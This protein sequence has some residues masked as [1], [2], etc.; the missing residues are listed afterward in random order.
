MKIILCFIYEGF[1]DFEITLTCSFL[2]ETE[3]YEIIYIAYNKTPVISGG[4]I[5][6]IPDKY[7]SEVSQTKDIEGIIIPGG[8]KRVLKPELRELISQL[9]QEKKLIAAICAGP[10]FLAKIGILKGITFTTSRKPSHYI[11]NNEID[12]FPRETY[13][14]TRVVQDGN[15]ITAKGFAFTDFALQIWDWFNLFDYNSEK[16]EYKQLYTP[17]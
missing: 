7:V 13:V 16:E 3:G 11:D 14:D 10:E 8:S 6:I 1:A 9:N 4:N 17:R 2:N 5:R 15:I 12:P